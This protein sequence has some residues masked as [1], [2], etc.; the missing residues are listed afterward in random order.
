MVKIAWK[1]INGYGPYA[2]L[3][4]SVKNN[5]KVTS[6]HIAYLGAAGK[7]GLVPGKNFTV[8][9][10][11]DFEGVR[12]MVP[13][14]G[15]ETVDALKPGPLAAIQCMKAQVEAGAAK[16]DIVVPGKGKTASTKAAAVAPKS[17]FTISSGLAP[18]RRE[19]PF[20]DWY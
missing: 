7:N 5:G 9:P 16:K 13:F 14:V 6:K 10:S 15:E 3:Q 2:Y 8:P 12:L 19:P 20:A 18:R 17:L 1:V 4:E 11:E